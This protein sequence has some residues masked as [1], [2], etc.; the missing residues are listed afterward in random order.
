[1]WGWARGCLVV[2]A[3][4]ALAGCGDI[5]GF[6]PFTSSTGDGG[7]VNPG[8]PLDSGNTSGTESGTPNPGM[9]GADA[10]DGAPTDED[11]GDA[12]ADAA[13]EEAAPPPLPEAAPPPPLP[14]PGKPGFDLTAG[15]SYSTNGQ[16]TLVGA[17]GEAPGGNNVSSSADY[18]LQGGV[19]A[20]TQ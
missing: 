5:L 9:T 13:E 1:M 14:T 10:D 15:G 19:I 16:Y 7:I 8:K 18:T 4:L 2:A 12:S 6:A 11:A 17:V 20:V 3:A